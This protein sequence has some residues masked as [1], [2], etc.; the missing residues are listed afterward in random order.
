MDNG[1]YKPIHDRIVKVTSQPV[2]WKTWRKLEHGML[3]RFR[4]ERLKLQALVWSASERHVLFVL[5]K[6]GWH[7]FNSLGS[8]SKHDSAAVHV[9]YIR[10]VSSLSDQLFCLRYFHEHRE[11]IYDTLW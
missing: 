7:W 5:I 9:G 6:N 10:F 2:D 11:T 8:R 1:E 4:K 3:Q